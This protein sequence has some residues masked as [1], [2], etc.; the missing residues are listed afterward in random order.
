MLRTHGRSIMSKRVSMNIWNFSS[1]IPP[2]RAQAQRRLIAR[3]FRVGVL[4]ASMTAVTR[5]N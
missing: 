4:Q 5:R 2:L 1:N 3:I